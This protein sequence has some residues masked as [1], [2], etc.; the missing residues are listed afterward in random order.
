MK[1][2][3]TER[4]F[5]YKG[6]LYKLGIFIVTVGVIVYFLPREGRFNYQFDINKPWKYGLLQAS[7]DF[8]IYKEDA[9]VQQEQDSIMR[10]YSPY[11]QL[12]KTVGERMIQQFKKAYSDSL[13][14]I[15]PVQAYPHHIERI[16]QL[17][18]EKGV[19]APN[20]WEKL[21]KDSTRSI[22][23]VDKN[24]SNQVAVSSLYSFKSAYEALIYADTLHYR[25][26][27]LQRCN[28]NEYIAPNLVYDASKSEAAKQDLLSELS[29]ANGFV[30]NGQKIIDRGEIIDSRTYNILRSLEKEWNKRSETVAEKRLTLLGQLLF[31]SLLIGCFM[32]YLEL[33][34]SD[35]YKKHRTLALLFIIIVAFPVISSVMVAHSFMSVYVVPFAMIPLIVR[36]FLDSRTAFMAHVITILLC[37]ICLRTPHEFILLQMAAGMAGI[38]S[39]RELSQRSQLFRSAVIVACAYALMYLALDLVHV[40]DVS[41]LSTHMYMNFI[42]N[43]ILLLFTYPLLFILEKRLAS[44]RM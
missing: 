1:S 26:N 39:L 38:Y 6:L 5:S 41:Q 35:Y 28:L 9:E 24:T 42:L 8:P 14:R 36:I 43:G 30:M 7:F 33:F 27:L 37:S 25:K 17:I 44:L 34:R 4:Q 11:Y 2:L 15:I 20:D 10:L 12:D 22:Q 40:S 31:V 32:I 16:L 23:L 3:Q 13:Y 18:Y 19:F 21:R 29:W